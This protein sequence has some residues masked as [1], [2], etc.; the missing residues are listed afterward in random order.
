M[1]TPV[2]VVVGGITVGGVGV[3]VTE[4]VG[5]VVKGGVGVGEG[6]VPEHAPRTNSEPIVTMANSSHSMQYLSRFIL[7]ITP[8]YKISLAVI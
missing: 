2:G 1:G 8:T 6:D 7:I 4:G 3:T 5:V